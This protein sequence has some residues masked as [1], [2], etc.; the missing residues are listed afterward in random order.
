MATFCRNV[1]EWVEEQ[2]EKP[3]ESWVNQQ[4]QRC[5]NEP[6]NWWML[7]LN[8]LVCWLVW[9]VVKVVTWVVVTVGKWVTRVVCE[10]VNFV[11]DVLAFVVNLV[12]SIPVIGGIIRTVL[13]WV[14]EVIWRVVGLI[15]LGLGAIG[16]RFEKKIHVSLL[17]PKSNGA[18]ITTEAAMMPQ[19]QKATELYKKLCNVKLV[20]KGACVA[21]FDA[22]SDALTV[23]CDASGF[24]SDWWLGGSYDQIA[25]ATCA[26]SDGWR[27]VL[28]Y[29]GEVVVI[30]VSN[31]TPDTATSLTVGCSFASTHDYVVVEPGSGPAV[32]A[33]EIGHACWLSHV[34]SSDNLMFASSLAAD[35]TLTSGQV[36]L[37]RWS[38]HCVYI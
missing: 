32:A 35:P 2:V 23:G 36:A 4:E 34:D 3:V 19:I 37:V 21:P 17:I 33:H 22:P 16:I 18:P 7:C 26:F 15:D 5:Q 6:C 12:L 11:L 20:Y 28:G 14:T 13:N 10:V 1:Q 31:V 24:F 9:V 27:R 30:A 29:G 38:K 8:K 25:T